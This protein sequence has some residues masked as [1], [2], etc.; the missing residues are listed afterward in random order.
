MP[1]DGGF[2]IQLIRHE[3]FNIVSFL[4]FDERAWLLV[5]DQVNLSRNS[6]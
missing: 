6:V 1:M 4:G 2:H 5:I 3:Y